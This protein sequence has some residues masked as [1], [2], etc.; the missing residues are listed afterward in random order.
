MLLARAASHPDAG[1]VHVDGINGCLPLNRPCRQALRPEPFGRPEISIP[2]VNGGGSPERTTADRHSSPNGANALFELIDVR[3]VTWAEPVLA[4]HADVDIERALLDSPNRIVQRIRVQAQGFE[5]GASPRL[6]LLEPGSGEV[7]RWCLRI[8][9]PCQAQIVV[10]IACANVH[11]AADWVEC[12][13]AVLA[14]G[15]GI[16]RQT[17]LAVPMKD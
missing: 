7:E 12:V 5:R 14:D 15:W 1:H 2:G 10:V 11:I 9:A 13:L 6:E 17:T 16:I 4:V 3:A 8:I